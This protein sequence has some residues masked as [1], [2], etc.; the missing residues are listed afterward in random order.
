MPLN[1]KF[2][3]QVASEIEIEWGEGDKMRSRIENGDWLGF[4][5]CTNP[6]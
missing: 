4:L 5:V 3:E 1:Y 6:V 2:H